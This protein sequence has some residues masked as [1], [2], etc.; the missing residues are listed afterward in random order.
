V[1]EVVDSVDPV[2]G[3][4]RGERVAYFARSLP[5]VERVSFPATT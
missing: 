5:E 1:G 3:D 2:A 4:R